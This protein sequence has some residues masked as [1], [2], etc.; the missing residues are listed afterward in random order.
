MTTQTLIDIAENR[1][2]SH[3][4]NPTEALFFD[5]IAKALRKLKQLEKSEEIRKRYRSGM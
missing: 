4:D 5:E 2:K 1:R 3:S